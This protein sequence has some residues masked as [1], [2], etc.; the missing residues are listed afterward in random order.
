MVT[1]AQNQLFIDFFRTGKHLTFAKNE[2][3]VGPAELP[4]GVYYIESGL[5]K[6]YDITKY[7]EE[8]LLI[9]RKDGELI[10][11]TWALTNNEHNIMSMA[12]A[13]TSI[14]LV[15]RERFIEFITTHPGAGVPV[16]ET[17]SKMYRMHGERIMTL[18]YRTV[19]E[20]LASFL[21]TMAG[22]FG[23]S[24]PVGIMIGA[25]LKQQDIASSINATR[26]TTSRTLA[27]MQQQ[28][29]VSIEQFY[30]TIHDQDALERIID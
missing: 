15:S 13:P 1:P 19:R 23:K 24:C 5:V 6:S 25:P 28:G 2:T 21:L 11:L 16:I 30:I 4:R 8:N 14:W 7:G 3:I 18:E 9:I 29:I 17:L 26:E 27:A 10:G 22:R 12:L 20:R